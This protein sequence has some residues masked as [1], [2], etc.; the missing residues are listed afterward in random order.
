MTSLRFHVRTPAAPDDVWA[1]VTDVALIPSWF[2]GVVAATFDGE[3]RHL[4]LADGSTLRAKVVTH[5]PVLRR[6]QY[7]F[8][9]GFPVPVDFHLGTLDVLEDG[10]GSL[11][12]YSQEVEPARLADFV[13]PAVAGGTR[14][15]ASY[16]AR[17]APTSGR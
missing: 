8:L 4:T 3:Q 6:F 16:L 7:R 17:N 2:P 11:V 14:G 12:V 13:G 1:V 10:S 5:D 15:I 9:D